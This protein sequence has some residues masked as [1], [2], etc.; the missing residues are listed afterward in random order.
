MLFLA[1]RPMAR[2]KRDD[3]G[4]DVGKAIAALHLEALAAG[5]AQDDPRA[6]SPQHTARAHLHGLE[7]SSCKR[8]PCR[9]AGFCHALAEITEH[10]TELERTKELLD[11]LEQT[12]EVSK[13][14]GNSGFRY[15]QALNALVE[16]GK[17]RHASEEKLRLARPAHDHALLC[18]RPLRIMRPLTA[19]LQ[20]L[21]NFE[22]DLRELLLSRHL[23][24]PA[25][26][27]GADVLLTAVW[28]HLDWGGLTY[29]E[30]ARLVPDRNGPNGA[31]ERVRSRVR[32]KNARCVMPREFHPELAA[33]RRRPDKRRRV[34][35]SA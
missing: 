29:A 34:R 7:P 28:Q 35:S 22:D 18:V 19:F 30:I 12:H 24:Q 14:L 23:R 25:D 16:H 8:S 6:A 31:A 10:R 13:W 5:A 1:E 32:S 15:V 2:R 9:L 11:V 3:V 20:S 21:D 27:K 17:D 4:F 26:R 33:D